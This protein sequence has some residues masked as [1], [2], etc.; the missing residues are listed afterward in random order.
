M[1][2][3]VDLNT[4]LLSDNLDDVI[5]KRV[6]AEKEQLQVIYQMLKELLKVTSSY[7]IVSPFLKESLTNAE[8]VLIQLEN[9]LNAMSAMAQDLKV[10]I[11]GINEPSI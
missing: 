11:K 6:L 9:H 10:T 1:S 5:R 3:L 8:L 2:S 4:K 7:R